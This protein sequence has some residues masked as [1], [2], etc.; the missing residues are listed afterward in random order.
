MVGDVVA[1]S[2]DGMNLSGSNEGRLG[3]KRDRPNELKEVWSE[4]LNVK[5]TRFILDWAGGL[6]VAASL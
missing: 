5:R 2:V 4:S 6:G 1:S 3:Y